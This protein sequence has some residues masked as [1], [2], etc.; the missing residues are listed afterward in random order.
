MTFWGPSGDAEEAI[1]GQI[2]LAVPAAVGQAVERWGEQLVRHEAP[3]RHSRWKSQ[4]A[5]QPRQAAQHQYSLVTP[6]VQYVEEGGSCEIATREAR[7]SHCLTTRCG[8]HQIEGV[9]LRK[10][11]QG[12]YR[13]GQYSHSRAREDIGPA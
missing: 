1:P 2:G 8:P 4:D 5:T 3:A 9:V 6:L 11:E 13:R 7:Q 10:A 12:Q